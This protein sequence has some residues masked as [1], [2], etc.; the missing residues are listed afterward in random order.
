MVSTVT[1]G[2]A[3]AAA[4]AREEGGSHRTQTAAQPAVGSVGRRHR[5]PPVPFWPCPAVP[6]RAASGATWSAPTTTSSPPARSPPSAPMVADSWR[7]S[8][9]SGVSPDGVLPSVD[10]L[11][12]EL[13][14]Y[15]SGTR[16]PR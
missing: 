6:P 15:R 1:A 7:L 3:I 11:D 5:V 14:A 12:A 10:M 2:A 16:W 13:E 9:A 4:R 8:R